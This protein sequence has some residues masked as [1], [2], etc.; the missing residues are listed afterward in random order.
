MSKRT[1]RRSC[2]RSVPPQLAPRPPRKCHACLAARFPLSLRKNGIQSARLL[3]HWIRVRNEESFSKASKA[4]TFHLLICDA[5]G[6]ARRALTTT[7]F[8]S[9]S[10]VIVSHRSA[11]IHTEEHPRAAHFD[12]EACSFPPYQVVITVLHRAEVSLLVFQVI[13]VTLPKIPQSKRNHRD[14]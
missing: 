4:A 11:P 1:S 3:L 13:L 6:G 8:D 5:N 9:K 14:V 10:S 12:C 2:L 7:I